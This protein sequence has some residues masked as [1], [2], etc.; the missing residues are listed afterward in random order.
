ALTVTGLL[1][2]TKFSFAL[3]YEKLAVIFGK[4][5]ASLRAVPLRYRAWQQARRERR[6]ARIEMRQHAKTGAAEFDSTA[7]ILPT[8]QTEIAGS[9]SENGSDVVN[10]FA[11][12]NGTTSEEARSM[13]AA[14]GAA[15]VPAKR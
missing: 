11:S 5:F 7:E 15:A 8:V 14:A 4:R 2:A 10:A 12:F 1:L 6:R 9:Q 3:L 13:A